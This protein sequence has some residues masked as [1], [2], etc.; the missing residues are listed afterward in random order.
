MTGSFLNQINCVFST[1]KRIMPA[2]APGKCEV[3]FA[4]V[5]IYH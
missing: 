1:L 3:H 5:F 2:D 4:V